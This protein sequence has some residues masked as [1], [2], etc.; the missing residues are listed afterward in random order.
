M[1]KIAVISAIL[2]EPSSTQKAF[3][4]VV[5]HFSALIRGRMGIPFDQEGVAV[6]SLTVVGTLDEI[7][8]FTGK[9]GNIPHVTVKT[10]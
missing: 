8:S 3:N 7:N 4:E 5:S 1:R 9:M 10:S 6:V 2:E